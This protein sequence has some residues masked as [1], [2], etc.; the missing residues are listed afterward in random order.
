MAFGA[1]YAAG[2]RVGYFVQHYA[3]FR[4]NPFK[5]HGEQWCDVRRITTALKVL[6]FS[7]QH[8]AQSACET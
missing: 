6:M 4:A 3:D 5:I 7:S 1:R 8:E 2:S